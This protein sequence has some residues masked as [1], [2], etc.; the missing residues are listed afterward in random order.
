MLRIVAAVKKERRNEIA[1]P[2]EVPL[3][4][5]WLFTSQKLELISLSQDF[6]WHSSAFKKNGDVDRHDCNNNDHYHHH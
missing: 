1:L 4:S 3:C 2:S 6:Y 5:R